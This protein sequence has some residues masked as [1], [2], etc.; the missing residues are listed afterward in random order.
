MKGAR[1]REGLLKLY[2]WLYVTLPAVKN[3][4]DAVTLFRWLTFSK[5]WRF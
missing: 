4:L 1:L 3:G 2:H 5:H